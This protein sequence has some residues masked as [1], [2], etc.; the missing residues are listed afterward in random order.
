MAPVS[1]SVQAHWHGI[2]LKDS[3]GRW[4]CSPLGFTGSHFRGPYPRSTTFFVKQKE[5]MN[6][7]QISNKVLH[8]IAMYTNTSLYTRSW[9]RNIIRYWVSL[10]WVCP[11]TTGSLRITDPLFGHLSKTEK[12]VF[13]WGL[14]VYLLKIRPINYLWFYL[15]ISIF[16]YLLMSFYIF[17]CL[18]IARKTEKS[19]GPTTNLEW[20][21]HSELAMLLCYRWPPHSLSATDQSASDAPQR[22]ERFFHHVW[23]QYSSA[24]FLHRTQSPPVSETHTHT[25]TH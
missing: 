9:H 21:C 4:T 14:N 6:K 16:L 11:V 3:W 10:T 18:S 5:V 15:S 8:F 13:S 12:M 23:G 1:F 17:L 7:V 19:W 25:D 22:S 20:G 2:W 24:G